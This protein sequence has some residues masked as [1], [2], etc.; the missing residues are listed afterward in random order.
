M[1]DT[2]TLHLHVYT[3]QNPFLDFSSLAGNWHAH[4]LSIIKSSSSQPALC[5]GGLGGDGTGGTGARSP[6]GVN[7]ISLTRDYDSL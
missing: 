5:G 7:Y 4:Q 1:N 2:V 3:F 6:V